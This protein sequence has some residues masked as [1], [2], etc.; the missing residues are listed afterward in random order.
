MNEVIRTI[1]NRRSVRLYREEQI[2]EEELQIIIEAGLWAPSG[3]NTQPWHIT[4]IQNKELL[5]HMSNIATKEMAKSPIEWVARMGRSGRNLFYNA[6]TV[7]IVSGKQE[8]EIMMN[9]AVDCAAA[10]QNMLL[11]AESLNIGS[12]W[13]G[14]ICFFF[15]DE[16]EVKKLLLPEG[17]KPLY[18]VCLGYKG[19]AN[20]KGPERKSENINYIR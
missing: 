8:D 20:G 19:R 9:S 13:I 1:K 15:A 10:I 12:C 5:A 11:A 4:A 7:L 17:V 2:A 16:E 6:P 18:A 14:L 3:H